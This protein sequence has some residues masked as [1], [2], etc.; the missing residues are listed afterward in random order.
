MSI[1]GTNKDIHPGMASEGWWEDFKQWCGA[2]PRLSRV[3][4]IGLGLLVLA[5]VIWAIYPKPAARRG[6]NNGPQPVGVA[7][8]HRTDPSM[9]L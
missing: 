7:G 4:F 1:E 3:L 9:S 5:V 2:H 6:L 8:E